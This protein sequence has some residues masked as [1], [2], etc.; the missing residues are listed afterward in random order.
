MRRRE[1][2]IASWLPSCFLHQCALISP[3][4]RTTTR[5]RSRMKASLGGLGCDSAQVAPVTPTLAGERCDEPGKG[6]E[7]KQQGK[8][9]GCTVSD[10]RQAAERIRM[11]QRGD[12]THS[13]LEHKRHRQM[14]DV[15]RAV[16]SADLFG[17]K[18]LAHDR[19]AQYSNAAE[20]CDRAP[21]Q[22]GG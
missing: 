12:E 15:Q 22:P 9:E 6:D 5:A 17:G 21:L 16:G 4:T 10:D 11:P 7:L 2:G 20:A 19:M 1:M 18:Q 13:V 8:R 14:Q 3:A